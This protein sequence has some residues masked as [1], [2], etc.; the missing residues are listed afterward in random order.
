MPAAKAVGILRTPVVRPIARP[1]YLP[2]AIGILHGQVI[3]PC[4]EL[5]TSW[6]DEQWMSLLV[7]ETAH[8][9]GAT[10]SWGFLQRLCVA[11]YWWN[12]LVGCLSANISWIR[13]Q[14]CD[15]L[16]VEH[17]GGAGSYA[18]LLVEFAC[19]IADGDDC[20]VGAGRR[21][22]IAERTAESR[23]PLDGA[24]P[25]DRHFAKPVG[26]L[27][28][29][30]LA[31]AIVLSPLAI[32]IHA[33][34]SAAGEAAK[35]DGPRK[36][37]D[38]AAKA[39]PP[40]HADSPTTN[41]EMLKKPV[42]VVDT[43]GRPVAGATIKG[44]G[45]GIAGRM[46]PVYP[47]VAMG[48]SIAIHPPWSPMPMARRFSISAFMRA[49]PRS[50]SLPHC[51]CRL[52]IPNL[53]Y[54]STHFLRSMGWASLFFQRLCSIAEHKSTSKPSMA[55]SRFPWTAFICCATYCDSLRAA[56]G[57]DTES[58]KL[59]A[60]GWL[61]SPRLPPPSA[62]VQLVYVPAS[63]P[64]MFSEPKE[65]TLNDGETDSVRMQ[66]KPATTVDGR[67]D[68]SVP[69]PVTNG[70]VVSQVI[71]VSKNTRQLALGCTF[72]RNQARRLISTSR[73]ATGRTASHCICDGYVAASGKPPDFDPQETTD[74]FSRHKS[75]RSPKN[76][77][78]SSR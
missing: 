52:N 13:E 60:N 47:G 75:S 58:V 68:A 43:E 67:L 6:R 53:R 49:K 66:M 54:L 10:C 41:H 19:R 51:T 15:D 20:R 3:L 5:Q 11:I 59:N 4:I 61:E 25:C 70:R 23:S 32:A 50:C 8:M 34:F 35:R 31:C 73:R 7:H 27:S 62:I 76:M 16:V 56:R 29:W 17:A 2:L 74:R 39:T 71:Q 1:T 12:P 42:R 9:P 77:R 36:R 69:R 57:I 28:D 33:N 44:F 40:E 78:L 14:I 38:T 72:G 64:V 21:R 55:R 63:G 45:I 48:L 46:A 30:P 26:D 37:S 22:R 18:K 24:S 65:M